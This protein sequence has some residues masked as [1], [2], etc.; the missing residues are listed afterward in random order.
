LIAADATE[1][2]T[3]A[4]QNLSNRCYMKEGKS[5]LAEPL[6]AAVLRIWDNIPLKAREHILENA[7]A[8][9]PAEAV[10]TQLLLLEANTGRTANAKPGMPEPDSLGG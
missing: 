2:L 1:V 8:A 3:S 10:R 7:L 4:R 6:G 9:H 5:L